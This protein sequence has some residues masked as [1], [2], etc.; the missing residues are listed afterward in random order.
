M[1]SSGRPITLL[2][3]VLAAAAARGEVV[4]RAEVVSTGEVVTVRSYADLADL[5]S[6]IVD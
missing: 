3:T 5:L 1:E 4:G 2:R 6:R